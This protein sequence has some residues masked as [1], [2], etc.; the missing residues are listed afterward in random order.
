MRLEKI[1]ALDNKYLESIGFTWHTDSDESSYIANELVVISEEEAEAFYEATNELYDMFIEGA[2]YVIDNELFHELN[3]PFN[4][5]EV[6]KESWE[7]DVHWHLYSRF[8]LAGGVDGKPIKL[9]EFNADTPTSLFETAI[10]QWAMLKK[11]GLDESSQFNNLYDALKDN[12]KRI[13]T[14]DSDIEKFDEY[15]S[16]LGWKILFSSIS[17]SS[18]DINTTKLLQHIAS[19]AGFN[20][21]FEFIENVNFSDDGIFKDDELFEFWFKLI[22]WEDIAIQ[23]SELALI[24]TEIIKEKRAII[25]NPAY[26]LIFQSKAFMK[27]LWDLYPN[28][29]LLLETSF[30]PLVGKKYVEKKTF[31]RE[32][33]NVKIINSDGSVEI[34]NGGEYEGHKSIFQEYVDFVKDSKGECY[35]AGVFYAYE[36]CG[37]GFRRG[38]KILNNMSKFVGHIIK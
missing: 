21:D 25:F 37:L 36:A 19:E 34:E 17:S 35:Q 5:V 29:P 9:I 22:P 1:E 30:E 14:L 32:G 28:H 23:E 8:D 4:L 10:I 11:N 20:T 38:G 33:A 3:I 2:Q 15:Y 24:L 16:K 26:T 31:G 7:N 18:E 6:I 13:I 27:I 12:F